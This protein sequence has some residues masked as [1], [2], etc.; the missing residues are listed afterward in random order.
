M[1]CASTTGS[2]RGSSRFDLLAAAML[3]VLAVARRRRRGSR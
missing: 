2:E 1:A 3:G